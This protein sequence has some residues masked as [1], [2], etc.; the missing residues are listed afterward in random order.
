MAETQKTKKKPPAPKGGGKK[1][2]SVQSCKRAYRA[3]GYC[4]FHYRKW[5]RG[6]LEGVNRRYSTCSGE[7]CKKKVLAHGLCQVHYDAWKKGR[8][9][10]K[11][12]APP[13]EKAPAAAPPPAPVAPAAT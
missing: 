7:E 6:E 13:A 5:R 10:A 4:F 11:L 2:C 8:M 12:A 1:T 9:G 3:K